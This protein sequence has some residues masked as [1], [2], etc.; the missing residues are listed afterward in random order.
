M[1][2]GSFVE[3][4]IIQTY[5]GEKVAPPMENP[6]DGIIEDIEF[7]RLFDIYDDFYEGGGDDDVLVDAMVMVSAR[8]PS[9]VIVMMVVTINLMTV[10]FQKRLR[11]S[12]GL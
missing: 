12:N 10:I 2:V 9:I 6:L 5:Y 1:L 7:D 4:Y 3:N 11:I 8:G